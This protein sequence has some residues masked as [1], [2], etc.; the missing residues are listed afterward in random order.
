MHP[1]VAQ[2]LLQLLFKLRQECSGKCD[3]PH[4]VNIDSQGRVQDPGVNALR[5]LARR[6]HCCRA[7]ASDASHCCE[8]GVEPAAT[9]E[10]RV[11]R[12][13]CLLSK[14]SSDFAHCSMMIFSF[15]LLSLP[16]RREEI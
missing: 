15:V 5:D 8:N 1:Q 11:E 2:S 13:L 9:A 10:N 4:H 12:C 3:I 16:R 7:L 14:D 6:D